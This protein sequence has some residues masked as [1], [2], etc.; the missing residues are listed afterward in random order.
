[1]RKSTARGFEM[2][3]D[4]G[5]RQRDDEGDHLQITPIANVVDTNYTVVAK[6]DKRFLPSKGKC[7]NGVHASF[8]NLA[9][10]HG[11]DS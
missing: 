1:M 7:W 9:K 4:V 2:K 5:D 3:R 11:S 6:V 10:R 8:K